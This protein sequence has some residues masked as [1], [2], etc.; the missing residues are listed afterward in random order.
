MRM[1]RYKRQIQLNCLSTSNLPI[2]ANAIIGPAFETVIIA[3]VLIAGVVVVVVDWRR[4]LR[5]AKV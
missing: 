1:E 5:R 4:I 3:S 2:L